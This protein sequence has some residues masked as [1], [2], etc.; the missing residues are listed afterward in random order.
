MACCRLSFLGS[1]IY[2]RVRLSHMY[3]K[4]GLRDHENRGECALTR[5]GRVSHSVRLACGY[6]RQSLSLYEPL[7]RDVTLLLFYG[8]LVSKETEENC[9]EIC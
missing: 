8:P 5:A 3:R 1:F 7:C 9:K 2:N 6:R 4:W